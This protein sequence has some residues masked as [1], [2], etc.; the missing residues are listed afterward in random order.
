[1]TN[2]REQDAVLDGALAQ[3]GRHDAGDAGAVARILHH[4]D[5]ITVSSQRP[6]PAVV[7]PAGISRRWLSFVMG[8]GAIAASLAIGL[9]VM[10]GAGA[11][12][13]E[14][15]AMVA[16]AD[17]MPPGPQNE[18]GSYELAAADREVDSFAMLFTLTSEE[19][20]YL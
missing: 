12:G 11:P 10:P 19:E 17:R 20:H 16:E 4:A 8:G 9:M 5:T 18:Q 2:D 3:W 1:M 15:A 13:G 6:Q 14:P 7:P